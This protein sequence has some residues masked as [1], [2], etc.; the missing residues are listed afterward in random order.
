M[1]CLNNFELGWRDPLVISSFVNPICNLLPLSDLTQKIVGCLLHF[2]LLSPFVHIGKVQGFLSFLLQF[3]HFSF[4]LVE[5]FY[6]LFI[7]LLRTHPKQLFW[8]HSGRNFV[9]FYHAGGLIHIYHFFQCFEFLQY[10]FSLCFVPDFSYQVLSSYHVNF[11]RLFHF[12]HN[13]VINGWATLVWLSTLGYLCFSC[14]LC[15]LLL[16]LFNLVWH[17]LRNSSNH[18]LFLLLSNSHVDWSPML[19]GN[20]L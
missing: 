3:V 19:H 13:L 14:L 20:S 1:W 17:V 9:S 8:G 5:Y 16:L 6:K 11:L 2:L 18:L 7:S 10:N 15:D 4:V 12:L